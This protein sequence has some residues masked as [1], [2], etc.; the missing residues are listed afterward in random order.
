[1]SDSPVVTPVPDDPGSTP[2]Q[3]DWR[4]VANIAVM[5]VTFYTLGMLYAW[6]VGAAWGLASKLAI[7]S[8]I[9]WIVG[10]LQRTGGIAFH[11]PEIK[12]ALTK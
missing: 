9:P 10:N 6:S 5:G 2:G 3:I 1:M 8:T 4:K 12:A 7:G 11:L